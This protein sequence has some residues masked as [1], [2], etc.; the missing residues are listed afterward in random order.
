MFTPDAEILASAA[1]YSGMLCRTQGYAKDD[2][3]SAALHGCVLFL[4]AM[5]LGFSVFTRNVRDFDF[6]LQLRPQ[7]RVL[8]YRR[9]E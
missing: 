6:L 2:R 4:Q 7:G 5:K 9:S 8:F 3:M 1:V